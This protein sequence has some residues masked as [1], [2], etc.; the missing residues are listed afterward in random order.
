MGDSF[1]VIQIQAFNAETSDFTQT[2]LLGLQTVTLR[3]QWNT[4][5]GFWFVSTKI[6]AVG[7]VKSIKCV[8]NWPLLEQYK[9]TLPLEGDLMLLPEGLGQPEYPTFDGLGVTHNLHWLSVE[10][11]ATWRTLNGLYED[12]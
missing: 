6:D 5:A 3:L 9:A 11:L 4:R 7:E 1:A 2:V 12:N 8:P 10:E